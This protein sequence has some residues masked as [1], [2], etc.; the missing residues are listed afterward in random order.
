MAGHSGIRGSEGKD[1]A[2]NLEQIRWEE[3]TMSLNIVQTRYG[4]V[5]GTPVDGYTV[6]RGIPY[7]AP[8]IGALRW[9]EPQ[10]PA[11]WTGIYQ[12]TEFPCKSMQEEP[13]IPAEGKLP[14]YVREFHND[15]D[16]EADSSED[17]LYLNI[18]T[19]AETGKEKLPVAF[20]I[21]GGAFA[22]GYGSEREFDGAAFCRQ[23]VIL[24]TINYR[25]NLFGFLAHP[26]L[27]EESEHH[28]SG[29]YG[30]LDQ[31]AALNWVYENI[32]GFGGDRDRIT[33]M[34]QSAGA[35]SVQTLVSSP[36][37]EDRI[38]GAI[39]QSAG[40]YGN[41]LM[42]DLPLEKA[43][44]Y[45]TELVELTGASSLEELRSKTAGELY[46]AYA[47]LKERR[48]EAGEE[49]LI[50]C[51]NVDGYVLPIGYARAVEQG[52]VKRIPYLLGS[53]KHDIFVPREEADAGIP[54]HLH[55]GCLKWCELLEQAGYPQS[56]VYRFDRE[57][58][59]DHAGAFHSADLWYMFGTLERCWRPM[60]EA[61][62]D[63]SR[64]MVKYWT[65]FVKTGQPSS[66]NPQDWQPC[67]T[68]TPFVKTL[69]I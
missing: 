13:K 19:P 47:I 48:V 44:E 66:K 24:V 1:R 32:E 20:W 43:M 59:G 8:P 68:G 25:L 62:T 40:G 46:T 41:G 18:W 42:T 57:L 39:M 12:A 21:H 37:T 3:I 27:N 49:F 15:R 67:S 34:G 10:P 65:D 17:S 69:N 38:T 23:G 7:A 2:N 4:A 61:D 58:P 35:M 45:G 55:V 60:T 16:F 63:L 22:D 14:F 26:W 51:P 31:I 52:A 11:S 36:L 9:R 28:V 50:M 29:N 30:I 53:T 56:Y 33:I 64:Q 54:S 5:E 6:F